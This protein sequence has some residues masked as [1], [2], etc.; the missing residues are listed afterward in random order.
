MVRLGHR[1][2]AMPMTA[3]ADDLCFMSGRHLAALIR[4]RKVSSREVMAAHLRQIERIN[5]TINAIVA[6]LDDRDCLALAEEA[7]RALMRNDRVG[8][9]HGLPWA[10][11]DLEAVVGFPFTNGSPLYESHV[12]S[13]NTLLVER[14]LAAGAIPIGKTNVPEFGMGSHTYNRVYGI[15]RNPY[16]TA[17]SA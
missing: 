1:S 8:P 2:A 16:D 13:D 11:K 14:I 5:P 4:S 10:F 3:P 17:K 7:D 15:T 12:P 6:K 9:L